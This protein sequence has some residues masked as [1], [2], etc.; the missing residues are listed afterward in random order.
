MIKKVF[1]KNPID[2]FILGHRESLKNAM[3]KGFELLGQGNVYGY[4][5]QEKQRIY[6]EGAIKA[7]ENIKI[8]T[9]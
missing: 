4:E 8:F 6:H 3:A 7:L 2:I 9:N 5:E 1:V